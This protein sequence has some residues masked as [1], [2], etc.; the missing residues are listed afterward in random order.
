VARTLRSVFKSVRIFRDSPPGENPNEASN[1][2]FFA[3]DAP[4]TFS[5]PAQSREKVLHSFQDWEVLKDVPEGQL[6][7]DSRN[8]LAVSS[9]LSQRNTSMG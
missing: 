3:S 2:I 9:S 7:T 6:I 4:V 1:L 5:I 8:P